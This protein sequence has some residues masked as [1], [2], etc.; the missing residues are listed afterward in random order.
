MGAVHFY[1]FSK[2]VEW[3]CDLNGDG[4]NDII[5]GNSTTIYALE[6]AAP[7]PE[8][9]ISTDKFKYGP[10]D[11]MLI[12]VNISNPTSDPVTFK[13]YLGIPTSDIGLPVASVPIPAVFEDTIEVTLHIGEWSETPFSA[14][15]YVDLQDPETGQELAAD[16]ACWSYCPTYGEEATTMPM[17]MPT[18]LEDIAKEI[19]EEIEGSVT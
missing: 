1:P 11:T 7:T 8:I 4:I 5:L 17:S 6:Y 16:C 10:G 2:P 12:T 19:G 18:L 3:G 15:W 14:V 13:G 9:S